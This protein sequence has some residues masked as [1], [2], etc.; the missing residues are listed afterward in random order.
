[1]EKF[2]RYYAISKGYQILIAT[3]LLLSLASQTYDIRIEVKKPAPDIFVE[4]REVNSTLVLSHVI[5][6]FAFLG[7]D[8]KY[9]AIGIGK[10]VCSGKAIAPETINKLADMYKSLLKRK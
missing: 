3:I 2:S 7:L 5:L 8:H 4:T 9:L 10:K 6:I 1:M